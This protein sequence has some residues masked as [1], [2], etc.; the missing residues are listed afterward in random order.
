MGTNQ[1]ALVNSRRQTSEE[2]SKRVR[3]AVDELTRSGITP[4]FY[5]VASL[6]GVSRSTLYRKPELRQIVEEARSCADHLL[7]SWHAALTQLETEN[8]SLRKQVALLQNALTN[9]SAKKAGLRFSGG[10]PRYEY[11][12]CRF[13]TEDLAA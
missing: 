1:N 2:I 6:S 9:K 3:A 11:A 10:K 7:P 5:S 13:E 8:E 12:V 4:S